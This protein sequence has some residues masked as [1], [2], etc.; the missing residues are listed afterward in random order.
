MS[1]EKLR[2]EALTCNRALRWTRVVFGRLMAAAAQDT[3]LVW[4]VF[5]GYGKMIFLSS[6]RCREVLVQ[7]ILAAHWCDKKK[8]KL[9]R[10]KSTVFLIILLTLSA[11]PAGLKLLK[12]H[13]WNVGLTTQSLLERSQQSF[14]SFFLFHEVIQIRLQLTG[15]FL[16]LTLHLDP[17]QFM[18]LGL[19]VSG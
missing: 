2:M 4:R 10:K 8:S 6:G 3:S 13:R 12:G 16:L 9:H 1:A 14:V 19:V 5:H 15:V 7:Q 11:S 17:K 18:K